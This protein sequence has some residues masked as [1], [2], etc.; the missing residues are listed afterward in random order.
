M[1]RTKIKGVKGMKTALNHSEPD[2][3]FYHPAWENHSE[4]SIPQALTTEEKETET[5]PVRVSSPVVSN[6]TPAS[7]GAIPVVSSQ[8][9]SQVGSNILIP[10]SNPADLAAMLMNP[11][12][13]SSQMGIWASFQPVLLAGN[14]APAAQALLDKPTCA[15]VDPA[16]VSTVSDDHSDG[17]SSKEENSNPSAEDI[18][19]DFSI[20]SFAKDLFE[21]DAVACNNAPPS[22]TSVTAWEDLL[23]PTPVREPCQC[24]GGTGMK[25]VDPTKNLYAL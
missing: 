18:P 14:P 3:D 2:L 4:P 12:L 11:S 20:L 1:K 19:D 10:F 25:L 23:D 16:N 21:D 7:S 5:P 13:Q 15:P 17:L 8:G 6:P 9:N 24:C 22:T